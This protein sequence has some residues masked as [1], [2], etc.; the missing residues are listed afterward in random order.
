MTELDPFLKP[1]L[2]I[3]RLHQVSVK[4]FAVGDPDQPLNAMQYG[5]LYAIATHPDIDQSSLA[6]LADLDRTSVI[7]VLDKLVSLGLIH[8]ESCPKDRRAR[9]M[10]LTPNGETFMQRFDP[11]AE[12]I[13][14]SLLAP[15]STEDQ[16]HFMR[17]L[18]QLV[19][20]HTTSLDNNNTHHL[21][22][23]DNHDQP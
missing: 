17:M 5:V 7:K 16:H 19:H 3:R 6:T 9:R 13:Q 18:Q 11:V 21:N 2:L 4:R 20:A 22:H 15:L 10:R 1:G 8:R 14:Q 23:G 12:N